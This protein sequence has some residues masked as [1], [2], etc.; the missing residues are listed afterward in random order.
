[1]CGN[2]R[3][4]Y[5]G[6]PADPSVCSEPCDGIPI[7]GPS[8]HGPYCPDFLRQLAVRTADNTYKHIRCPACRCVLLGFAPVAPQRVLPNSLTPGTSWI[9]GDG[10]P[11]PLDRD[12]FKNEYTIMYQIH[13][14][15]NWEYRQV[16]PLEP[17]CPSEDDL[18]REALL[19]KLLIKK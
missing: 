11:G 19:E 8:G 13:C 18:W 2:N 9:A 15:E 4:L 17:W 14:K 3:I 7:H 6:I 16:I 1:M 10:V 12:Q 5:N